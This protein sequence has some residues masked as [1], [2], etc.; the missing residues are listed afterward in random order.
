M[1]ALNIKIAD[2][3]TDQSEPPVLVNEQ[4]K[5]LL[6]ILKTRQKE[7]V[8]EDRVLKEVVSFVEER[9]TFFGKIRSSQW[10][11]IRNIATSATNDETMMKSL[12]F[13]FLG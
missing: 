10:S 12:F 9:K 3:V 4:D 11:N 1:L 8:A 6:E 13:F 2:S 5:A 7:T